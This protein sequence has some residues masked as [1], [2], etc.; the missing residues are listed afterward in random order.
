[1]TMTIS[2]L[3][4]N[5]ITLGNLLSIAATFGSAAVVIV[6]VTL[7]YGALQSNDRMHDE[8]IRQNREMLASARASRDLQIAEIRKELDARNIDHDLLIEVNSQL[9][10]LL[11]SLPPAGTMPR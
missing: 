8:G 7:A 9:K 11:R 10:T 4:K 5:G 6:T 1:M 3:Q 2:D